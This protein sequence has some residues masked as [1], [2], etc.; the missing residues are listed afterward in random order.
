ME[1]F[2]SHSSHDAILAKA[3][4]KLLSAS[5]NVPAESIRCTS[6]AG[7]KLPLGAATDDQLK[8]EVSDSKAFVAL[9]T[10]SSIKSPYVLFEMGARWG[11]GLF[12]GP[13]LARGTKM[14]ELGPI[15]GVNALN[16]SDEADLH[17]FLS[18]VAAQLGRKLNA[19]SVYLAELKSVLAAA[20][21]AATPMPAAVESLVMTELGEIKKTLGQTRRTFSIDG[22]ST[23]CVR[24]EALDGDVATKI[25][26]K[27]LGI[28]LRDFA[29]TFQEP[30]HVHWTFPTKTEIPAVFLEKLA[31]EFKLSIRL[32][33]GGPAL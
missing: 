27:F 28:G 24:G 22:A 2:I 13:L 30:G 12:L 6:V 23:L 15:G 8:Q 10:P 3:V 26:D 32:N 21:E 29:S 33:A 31:S 11:K 5:L 25:S 18:D 4:A 1:I 19:V 9:I 16:A 14:A 7:Y 20:G 17:Q